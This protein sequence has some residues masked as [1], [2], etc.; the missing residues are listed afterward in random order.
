M[1]SKQ[2][3]LAFITLA[4]FGLIGCQNNS[5][6]NK[7]ANENANKPASNAN[8]NASNKPETGSTANATPKVET[9]TASVSASTPTEAYKSAYTA[10]KNKDIE[11]L[12]KLFA[13]DMF[14]FF[15]ILGEGKPNP[16]DE[17]LKEMCESPQNP[18]A[19]VRNE[20]IKGEKATLEY[21]DK[22]GK[23]IPMDFVKEDGI[24]KLTIDKEGIK[25]ETIK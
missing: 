6:T 9:N 10:R 3:I 15:E 25:V 18:S 20:K 16:V 24:W 5:T 19:E 22:D 4:A 17:A 2:L 12:K 14:E 1:K 8:Q 23:W 21:L 11:T 13:K 7:T